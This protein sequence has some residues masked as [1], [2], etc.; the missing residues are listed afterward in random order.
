MEPSLHLHP[1]GGA[2]YRRF[3]KFSI[4]H[5]GSLGR[6]TNDPLDRVHEVPSGQHDAQ[7]R[8]R[9]APFDDLPRAQDAYCVGMT[10]KAARAF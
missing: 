10:I 6:H 3:S 7:P 1:F 5:A 2:A 9:V 4:R 8:V